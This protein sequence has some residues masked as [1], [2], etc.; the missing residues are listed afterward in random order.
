[1]VKEHS[2]FCLLYF[3][4]TAVGSFVATIGGL[5]SVGTVLVGLPFD[6][7]GH[8]SANY[9]DYFSLFTLFLCITGSLAVMWHGA[10]FALDKALSPAR[11]IWWALIVS[12]VASVPAWILLLPGTLT[13]P[14]VCAG[15]RAFKNPPRNLSIKE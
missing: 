14:F 2:P 7:T 8:L 12:G 10:V 6:Q 9:G 11:R 5:A 13:K 15:Y 4:E 1:M 3:G